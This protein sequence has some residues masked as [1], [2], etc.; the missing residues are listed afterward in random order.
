MSDQLSESVV[1]SW[2]RLAR[3]SQGVLAAVEADLKTAGQ[4]PLTWYDALLELKRVGEDGLRPAELQARML[5]A[6]YNLSRLLVRLE[7]A[8][9]VVRR[10]CPEDGRGQIVTI[11]GAGRR[12]LPRMWRV[13]HSAIRAHFADKLTVAEAKTL[14]DLLGKITPG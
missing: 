6:Q 3:V 8:G 13:Y 1:A 7:Q 10:P 14:G 5:L 12:L 11:T 9:Y 4:P 2:A